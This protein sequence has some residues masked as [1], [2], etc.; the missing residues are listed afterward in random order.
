PAASPDEQGALEPLFPT[1][2][3]PMKPLAQPVGASKENAR[4]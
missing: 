4:G 3:L 2:P 1:P